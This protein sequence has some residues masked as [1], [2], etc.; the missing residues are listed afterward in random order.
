[1]SQRGHRE[2]KKNYVLGL[3]QNRRKRRCAS[4]RR[5]CEGGDG[6]LQ[7]SS[8]LG[9]RYNG[10]KELRVAERVALKSCSCPIFMSYQGFLPRPFIGCCYFRIETAGAQN[11]RTLKTHTQCAQ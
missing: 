6:E 10:A 4:S 1:M 7:V 9:E 8:W 3:E 2:D 5:G 11:R